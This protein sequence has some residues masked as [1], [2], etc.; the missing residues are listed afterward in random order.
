MYP[1]SD[2][3][4]LFFLK[5]QSLWTQRKQN[6]HSGGTSAASSVFASD[7]LDGVTTDVFKT[8]MEFGRAKTALWHG[9]V[10]PRAVTSART[11]FYE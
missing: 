5:I 2:V 11:G 1:F 9:Q 6:A 3:E 7:G 10:A 8:S 4:P